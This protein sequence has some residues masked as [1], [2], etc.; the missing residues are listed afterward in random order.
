[1]PKHKRRHW[2]SVESRLHFAKPHVDGYEEWLREHGYKPSTIEENVRLLAGWTDWMHTAGFAFDNILDGLAASAAVFK[3]NKSIRAYIGAGRLFI[4]YLEDRGTLPRSS[5][6]PS[7]AEQWPILGAFRTWARQ[8]RGIA[9]S[10]LDLWQRPIIDLLRTL[11]EDPEAYT[12]AALR[13]FMLER[14][15]RYKVGRLKTYAVAIRGFLRFLVATGQCPVG[16]DW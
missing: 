8:Q 3:G 1:M 13:T 10:T 11:G 5:S 14:A 12:A 9:H 15:K 7:P 2:N 4:R 16:R 6:P